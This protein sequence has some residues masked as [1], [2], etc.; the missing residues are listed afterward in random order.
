MNKLF[1]AANSDERQA[2]VTTAYVAVW[3]EVRTKA[4]FEAPTNPGSYGIYLVGRGRETSHWGA[5][6]AMADDTLRAF[7]IERILDLL[8]EERGIIVH[9][10]G[11]MDQINPTNGHVRGARRRPG[12]RTASGQEYDAFLLINSI[13]VA[14]DDGRWVP[15]VI[16]KRSEPDGYWVAEK[17]AET[18]GQEAAIRN[19]PLFPRY[20]EIHPR[21]F[22]IET[23]ATPAPIQLAEGE[24]A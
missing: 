19:R 13:T 22:I 10:K 16:R 9:T 6:Y 21:N 3:N 1:I 15:Q 20:S 17:V 8:P 23:E 12:N 14:M 24:A 4:A 7:A 5:G 11:L 2:D 18:D